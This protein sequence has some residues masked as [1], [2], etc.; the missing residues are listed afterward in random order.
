MGD[1]VAMKAIKQELSKMGLVDGVSG[2]SSSSNLSI[3]RASKSSL[4]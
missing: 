4:E 3:S 1:L 2:Q